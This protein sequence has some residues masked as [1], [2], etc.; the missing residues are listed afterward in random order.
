MELQLVFNLI[1]LY[2]T[3]ILTLFGLASLIHEGL[4]APAIS[5]V[6]LSIIVVFSIYFIIEKKRILL[7]NGS[8]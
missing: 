7:I 2:L 6:V 8:I 4:G 5:S 1:L 3:L